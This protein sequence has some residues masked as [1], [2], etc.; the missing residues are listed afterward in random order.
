MKDDRIQLVCQHLSDSLSLLTCERVLC[1]RHM[2]CVCIPLCTIKTPEMW[3]TLNFM[4]QTSSPVPTVPELYKIR[5]QSSTSFVRLCANSG[6]WIQKPGYSTVDHCA[7]SFQHCKATE[8]YESDD[9]E[10]YESDDSCAHQPKNTLPWL[11]EINVDHVET[12]HTVTT[13]L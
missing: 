9:S 8:R 13:D 2:I 4:K 3:K 12:M 6:M 11:P 10:R 5:R 1:M 7:S